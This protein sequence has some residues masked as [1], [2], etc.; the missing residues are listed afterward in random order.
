MTNKAYL[1]IEKILSANDTSE[2]GAHQAGICVP[3]KAEILSY[4]PK[5][6]VSIKNPRMTLDFY[7]DAMEKWK[8]NFIYYNNRY[9]GGTRNEYRLTCITAYMKRHSLSPGDILVF[10]H[11]G[12]RR[13]RISFRKAGLKK[14]AQDG[15]LVLG[16]GWKVI[17]MGGK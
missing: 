11:D 17:Q 13:R 5:L 14:K 12:L 10:S 16:K 8:L 6:N 3:K 9:F 15:W 1:S 4:F 2:T 7:D